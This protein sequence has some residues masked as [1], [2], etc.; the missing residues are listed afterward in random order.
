MRLLLPSLR[1][2]LPLPAERPLRLG[3]PRRILCMA[4]IIAST[5]RWPWWRWWN[6][7]LGYEVTCGLL[8]MLLGICEL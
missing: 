7:A 1:H 3:V 4:V 8:L 5:W 6:V 2:L